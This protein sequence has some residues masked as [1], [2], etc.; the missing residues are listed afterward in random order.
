MVWFEQRRLSADADVAVGPVGSERIELTQKLPRHGERLVAE[1]CERALY[2]SPLFVLPGE[3][4][5]HFGQACFDVRLHTGPSSR[6]NPHRSGPVASC[7]RGSNL[8]ELRSLTEHGI[9]IRERK[10]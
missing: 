7:Y 1:P 6:F 8:S 5:R 4:A 3:L 2:T 10:W 9:E